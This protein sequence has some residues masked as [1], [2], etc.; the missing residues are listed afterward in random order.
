MANLNDYFT[1]RQLTDKALN[2]YQ[3]FAIDRDWRVGRSGKLGLYQ[4]GRRAFDS[5]TASP[6]AQSAFREAYDIVRS[7]PGVQRGGSLAGADEV[8][9][10]IRAGGKSLVGIDSV[11]LSNL[12]YPSVQSKDIDRF[13][14]A[15]SFIKPTKRYPWMPVSK[16]LHFCNPRLFP[17]W[18]WDVM[19]NEVMWE[20]GPFR[21]EFDRFCG[22]RQFKATSNE[23]AFLLYYTLWAA[24]YVQAADDN[25]MSWFEEWM[26]KYYGPDIASTQMTPDIA[27]LY[28]TAF[29]FVAIG[30]AYLEAGK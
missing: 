4:L 15:L 30:A 8:F 25:F 28:S 7:W 12:S 21:R 19:W 10:A 16:V 20:K 3:R 2:R 9:A 23:P 1:N 29:E 24:S 18:D 13:L 6:V 27:T 5:T 14:P 26:H 17:I 11:S 22:A